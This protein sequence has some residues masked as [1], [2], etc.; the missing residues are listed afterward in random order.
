MVAGLSG[1]L[2]L[3]CLVATRAS[4]EQ[5]AIDREERDR[6]AWEELVP[7]GAATEA[8]D[9]AGATAY[10]ENMARWA[11]A[12]LELTEHAARTDA[13]S[14][15]DVAKELASAADD[16]R[17]LRTLL[18]ADSG[19]P[20]TAVRM[21]TL[22]NICELWEADQVRIEQLAASVDPDWHR[23]WRARSIVERL[24]RRGGAEAEALVLP[25]RS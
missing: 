11:E 13:A 23:R 25:Y 4:R 21:A 8:T 7:A 2:A 3:A 10:V 22:H 17:E 5:D 15:A 20:I 12:M 14:Q 18:L 1:A 24:V 16:A 19:T 9:E 6:P